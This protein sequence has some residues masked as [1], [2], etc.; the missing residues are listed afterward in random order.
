MLCRQ[1]C[2]LELQRYRKLGNKKAR[3]MI[4]KA[5]FDRFARFL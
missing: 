5:I 2:L 3:K 1:C 4:A